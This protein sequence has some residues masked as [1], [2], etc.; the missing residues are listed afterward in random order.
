VAATMLVV[1]AMLVWV[2]TVFF[3]EGHRWGQIGLFAL[4]LV[5][6]FASIAL[7]FVLSPPPVFV[8]VAVVSLLVEGVTAVCLWHPDTLGYLAEDQTF[9]TVLYPTDLFKFYAACYPTW[10]WG[11]AESIVAKFQIPV[12][13]PMKALSKG[14]QRQV[15]LVCAVAHRPR[16]LVLDEPGGGLDPVVRRSFLE[17]VIGL[18]STEETCVLFS[19]HHLQEVERLARRIGIMDRGRLVVDEELD[20]LREGSCRVLAEI[21]EQ[22]GEVIRERIAGCVSALKRDDAWM[23]TMRCTVDE[24]KQRVS[25]AVNGRP[26]RMISLARRSPTARGRFCVPPAPGMMPSVTSVNAKRALSAA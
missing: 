10:D 22:N 19:S 4:V 6:V 14:Q 9:P 23:L 8:V 1:T 18:L 25:R 3:H 17:E 24:A 13:R 5:A 20:R 2:L 15:S 7:G 12:S 16:L 11:F 21:D 26:V